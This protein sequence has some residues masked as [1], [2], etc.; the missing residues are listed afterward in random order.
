MNSTTATGAQSF[1]FDVQVLSSP[2][3]LHSLN[4]CLSAQKSSNAS[5]NECMRPL[6]IMCGVASD[7]EVSIP[8]RSFNGE[9][10]RHIP[11]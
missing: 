6:I 9:N 1:S 10:P 2:P 7:D 4:D 3:L 5:F 8:E 11:C